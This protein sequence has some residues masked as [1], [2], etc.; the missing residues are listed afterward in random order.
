LT[1]AE[2]PV[3]LRHRPDVTFT[4]VFPFFPSCS[5]YVSYSFSF[6]PHIFRKISSLNCSNTS[7]VLPKEKPALLSKT[8]SSLYVS[9]I[10]LRLS[11]LCS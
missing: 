11:F 1:D 9:R 7:N 5:M 2:L 10:T 3:A 4:P 8:V 6:F